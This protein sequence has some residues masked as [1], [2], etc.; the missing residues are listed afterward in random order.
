MN[1]NNQHK[2][3]QTYRI[4][5]VQVERLWPVQLICDSITG[6]LEDTVDE[7]IILV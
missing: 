3:K 1:M 5:D 2:M 4:P 6:D 7:P